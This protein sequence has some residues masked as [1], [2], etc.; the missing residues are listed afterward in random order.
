MKTNTGL[1]LLTWATQPKTPPVNT[2]PTTPPTTGLLSMEDANWAQSMA[3]I[4]QAW[5]ATFG[6][7]VALPL[8]AP[9]ARNPLST[10]AYNRK[11][12]RTRGRDARAVPNARTREQGRGGGLGWGGFGVSATCAPG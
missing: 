2:P 9:R 11:R 4:Y 6:R 12:D 1:I 8:S 3:Q 5:E 7:S 10:P